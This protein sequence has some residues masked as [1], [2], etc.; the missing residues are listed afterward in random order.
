M[1]SLLDTLDSNVGVIS[2][3][4]ADRLDPG[5]H[6]DE[7]GSPDLRETGLLNP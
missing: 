4:A 2:G 1:S 3:I 7:E 6:P 5:L